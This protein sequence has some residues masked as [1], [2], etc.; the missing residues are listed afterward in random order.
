M[1]LDGHDRTL[2]AQAGGMDRQTL[3]DW[4]HRCT[5]EG[6]DGLVDRPRPGRRPRLDPSPQKQVAQWLDEGADLARNG[7]VRWRCADL[8]KRIKLVF[9]LDLQ[10]GAVGRLL[11]KPGDSRLSG[12]PLHPQ[13]NLEAQEVLRERLRRGFTGRLECDSWAV[14]LTATTDTDAQTQ[15]AQTA[16]LRHRS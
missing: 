14:G 16:R 2:A 6:V 10:E 15:V 1:V 4:A 9:D 7:V 3:R 5:A 13:S 11:K 8:V 12:R